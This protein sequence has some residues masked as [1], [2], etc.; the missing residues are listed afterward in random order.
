MIGFRKLSDDEFQ[1]QKIQMLATLRQDLVSRDI[2]TKEDKINFIN[3]LNLI[4]NGQKEIFLEAI[5][6]G[7][8]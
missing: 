2:Q 5:N 4:H 3:N 6:G 8:V 1:A 7:I